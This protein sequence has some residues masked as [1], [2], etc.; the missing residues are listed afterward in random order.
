MKFSCSRPELYEIVSNVSRAVSGKSALP[1]LEGVL[2]RAKGKVLSLM[3]YDLDLGISAQMQAK[4]E[5]DGEIVLSAK[6]FVDMM[7][8]MNGDTVLIETD[9]K[10]LTQIKSGS[11]EFTI[12]GIPADEFPEMPA[13]QEESSIDLPQH[14]L[15]SMIDQTLFAISTNDAKP[16]HTGSL[17]Q[18]E[19]G[20]LRVISV[21]GFRLALRREKVNAQGSAQ[22][23]IPGKTL[24]EMN[25]LLSDEEEEQT[26]LFL[27]KKH[28]VVS[29]GQYK[30]ISR[31]LE[32]EFLDYKAAIPAGMNTTVT[33]GV[34]ELIDSI[35]RTSLLISDR[36]KSPLRIHFTDGQIE[37][38]C[39][40]AIG[41]AYDA[42][43]CAL[44]GDEVEIGFNN[45]YMLEALRASGC[46]K[47]KLLISGPLS[48]MKMVPLEGD[49]F[50]FLIL[51][52]RLKS[53]I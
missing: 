11:S 33:V 18:L 46:D 51:P 4:I 3:G 38:S 37:M 13:V 39:S 34:R 26:R 1:V 14:L 53:E 32:G 49:S 15:K 28:V 24:S 22:F 20:E 16:V 31:L 23:I 12:L 29:V 42:L 43:S 9:E 30:L 6:L 50:L 25:K 8:R 40:T 2:L 41:K 17:F 35:E 21:D 10:Y 52:V 48:P 36:L 27:S 5:E 7:R 47:V 45:R 19:E 44:E